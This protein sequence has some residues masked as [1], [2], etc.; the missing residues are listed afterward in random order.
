MKRIKITRRPTKINIQLT[1]KHNK[2]KISLLVVVSDLK[3]C[4]TT[5]LKWQ[6]A[7]DL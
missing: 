3:L 4:N 1:H 2:N 6:F 7:F 5:A